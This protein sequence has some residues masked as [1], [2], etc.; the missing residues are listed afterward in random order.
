MNQEFEDRVRVAINR[1]IFDRGYAPDVARLS[2]LLNVS[3]GSVKAALNELVKSNALILHPNSFNIWIAHP[4]ALFPTLF[5]VESGEHKCWANCAWCSLGIAAL[6][7]NPTK[8]FSRIGGE[9]EPV[10]IDVKDGQVLQ[11]ELFVH[12]PIPVKKLWENVIYAC[13][14]MIVFR[15]EI[16]VECWCNRHN[17][18]K[19]EIRSI[20]EVW[21]LA[22]LWYGNYLQDTWKRK[23]P[24]YAHHLLVQAGFTGEFW[25]IT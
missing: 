15:D 7:D 2:K 17:V 20:T 11:Q 9:V 21:S 4:F 1:Y 10:V 19:G 3:E 8:I 25:K 22:K 13:S 14:N 18:V 24:E 12:F 23:T 16:Q 5:W 6:T